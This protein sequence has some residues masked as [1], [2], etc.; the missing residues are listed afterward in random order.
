MFF[1]ELGS[2]LKTFNYSLEKGE[3]SS[4]QKQDVITLIQKK[5][6]DVKIASKPLGKVLTSLK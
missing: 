6:R 5:D 2:L 1:G 3:L 4:S